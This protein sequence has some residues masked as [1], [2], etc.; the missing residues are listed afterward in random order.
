MKKVG[1]AFLVLL[2]LAAA[3]YAAIMWLSTQTS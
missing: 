1:C 3:A 2:A